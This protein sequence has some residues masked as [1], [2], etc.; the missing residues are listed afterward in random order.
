LPAA[1]SQKTES[2]SGKAFDIELLEVRLIDAGSFERKAGPRYRLSYRNNGQVESPKFLVTVAVDAG[3][4][5]TETA[6]IV[7]VEAVG[8]KPGKTQS[9]DVRMPVEVLTM[10]MAK[11]G[12]FVPFKLLAAIVDSDDSLE[13]TNED[14]NLMVLS[15]DAIKSV[16]N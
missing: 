12:R 2:T 5:L 14:N 4:K 6:E 11:D 1:Q 3:E 9:V 13:E 15:R 7:T 10:A 8:V 16:K